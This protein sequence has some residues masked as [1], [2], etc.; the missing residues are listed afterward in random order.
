MLAVERQEQILEILRKQRY[1]TVE[2]L[3]GILFASGATVR[4]DLAELEKRG[5][6]TRIR[7]GAALLEGLNM[8][9]PLPVRVNT[10]TEKKKKIAQLALPLIG[11]SMT[12]FMDSSSTV[13]ALAERMTGFRHLSVVTNGLGTANILNEKSA[14]KVFLCGGLIQEH[15]A[16]IGSVAC[17]MIEQFCA[18]IVFLSCCGLSAEMGATEASEETVKIKQAMLRN[19]RRKV[20]LCDSSKFGSAYFCKSCRLNQLDIIVTDEKP[21]RE[22][23]RF[24]P[25]GLRLIYPQAKE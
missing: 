6:I 19:A 7:G 9:A 23:M 3:C 14:A 15:A 25:E 2:A 16:L 1:I 10:N 21:D 17:D 12:I 5:G 24:I 13:S 22:F 18:D 20:L 8:D 11:E 4:R